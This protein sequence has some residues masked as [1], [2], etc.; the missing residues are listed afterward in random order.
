MS[1]AT[2]VVAAAMAA[3][4]MSLLPLFGDAPL[5][6]DPRLAVLCML[7]ASIP[8]VVLVHLAFR[9]RGSLAAFFACGVVCRAMLLAP[10]EG[11][12]DDL[13]RYLWEG[14]LLLAGENPYHHPP[15][16]PRLAGLRDDAVWPR[17]TH[18]DVPAAYPPLA[19]AFFAGVVA[20]GGGPDAMRLWLT[21]V[22]LLIW[23]LL[24][25]L[26]VARGLDPRR[27]VVW[28]LSPLVLLEVAGS[29]H[30]DV[31][32]V[33]GTV[34][35][36]LLAARGR[37]RLAAVG[38]GL[39]TIAKPYAPVLL[40]FV[41]TRRRWLVQGILFAG[42]IALAYAPFAVGGS[43][44]AGVSRYAETWSHNAPVYPIALELADGFKQVAA[45]SLERL[46]ASAAVRDVAY[47]I[48]PNRL[49]RGVLLLAL[50]C[51]VASAWRSA[52]QRES[53]AVVALAAF[54]F[55]AP[56]VHPWYLLWFVPF[57]AFELS[58]PL[59]LWTSS[60]LLSYHV[61]PRYDATGEWVEDPAMRVAEY[62]PVLAWLAWRAWSRWRGGSK[63]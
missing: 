29:G 18:P 20:L 36:L 49:A 4:P 35:A 56:T 45:S 30:L 59:L 23:V 50:A 54:L 5:R 14:R 6:A 24:I 21:G 41:L 31:L 38:V 37:E 22:D 25:K 33:A 2:G 11:L 32:A 42:V 62:A 52:W 53:K 16:D 57:L 27:S 8:Y 39:A 17:V 19:Q 61:L 47:G 34:V 48:D 40:P 43:P 9:G 13:Y 26:L 44:F 10:A 63:V 7:A 3:L 1:R 51:V 15:S 55:L 28:G 46:G 58:P 60:V 12:S